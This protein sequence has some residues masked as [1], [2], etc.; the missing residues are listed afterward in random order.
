ML[1]SGFKDDAS[2]QHLTSSSMDVEVRFEHTVLVGLSKHFNLAVET[3]N[4]PKS[5]C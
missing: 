5:R 1:C 2:Q 4:G 3:S